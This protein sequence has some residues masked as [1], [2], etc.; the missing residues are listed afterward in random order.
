MQENDYKGTP[1]RPWLRFELV[2]PDGTTRIL[3]AVADT[4]NPLPLIVSSAVMAGFCHL[5]G[6]GT[7]TNFGR[8]EGGFLHV[9]ILET[10]A[11]AMIFGYASDHVA[12]AIRASNL[13]FEGLVGLPLL[14]KLEFGGDADR[15][16]IR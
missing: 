1:P 12:D 7:D 3:E 13:D 10:G 6:P 4:G 9:R 14:R 8:L 5:G 11:D 2:A 16:W 15:F